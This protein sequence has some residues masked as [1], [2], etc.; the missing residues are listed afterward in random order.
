MSW[1]N[2]YE[3]VIDF[4]MSSAQPRF[5]AGYESHGPSA[6]CICLPGVLPELKSLSP[7]LLRSLFL[8]YVTFMCTR[9]SVLWKS[10]GQNGGRISWRLL[11][12]RMAQ[13][14]I[15]KQSARANFLITYL[16]LRNSTGQK[17][18]ADPAAILA[19]RFSQHWLQL[20]KAYNSFSSSS[21]GTDNI[22][23]KV[24]QLCLPSLITP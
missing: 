3:V 4:P 18:P 15:R 13:K 1:K 12:W 7:P 14:Q 24:L 8:S 16:F 23:I 20:Y 6:S 11:T 10:H 17:A 22:S 21:V 5:H 2:L 9:T 19:V